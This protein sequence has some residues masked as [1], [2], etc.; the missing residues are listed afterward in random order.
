MVI[1]EELGFCFVRVPRTASTSIAEALLRLP[2]SKA[3]LAGQVA[4]HLQIPKKLKPWAVVREPYAR[5]LS[6]YWRRR[7]GTGD[8]L[9]SVVRGLSFK[10]YLRELP[11]HALAFDRAQSEW[12]PEEVEVLRYEELPN[13]LPDYVPELK[14]LNK[15]MATGDGYDGESAQIVYEMRRADFDV[16]GYDKDGWMGFNAEEYW[17]ERQRYADSSGNYKYT[18]EQRDEHREFKR[19]VLLG[20][21]NRHT[22]VETLA[23]FGA[24]DG[25]IT[26]DLLV[27]VDRLDISPEAVARMPSGRV[28]TAADLVPVDMIVAYDVLFHI[29]D[30]ERFAE[31]LVHIRKNCKLLLV[32]DGFYTTD[33]TMAR[34]CR[35][36]SMRE[37]GGFTEL[38]TWKLPNLPG[39]ATSRIKLLS[40][41]RHEV[42]RIEEVEEKEEVL[43]RNDDSTPFYDQF[44]GRGGWPYN[45]EKEHVALQP[46][47]RAAGWKKKFKILE[48]GCGMGTHAKILAFM[49]MDVWAVDVSEVAIEMAR[50]Q[51]GTSKNLHY[52][53]ADV[54]DVGKWRNDMEPFDGI[55]A[56]GMSYFHYELGGVNCKGIDV[57]HQTERM[58]SWLRDGGTFVLQI[59]TDLSGDR[60]DTVHSNT[61]RDYLDLFERFGRV[62]S[63]T[64]LEGNPVDE[65]TKGDPTRGPSKQGIILVVEKHGN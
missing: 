65:M 40:V 46:V 19:A 59:C 54:A 16:Y 24:G 53:A 18:Q 58:F 12:L 43:T 35:H 15:C 50:K 42:E 6:V 38:S 1:N 57:S 30:D 27:E 8:Y 23:D 33:K 17:L 55:Y 52:V 45:F 64:D 62:V 21:L 11:K 49:G 41:D 56:R 31:A 37:Y 7:A 22:W 26:R 2:G 61:Y 3:V 25:W 47:V 20:I 28:G 13:C 48:V 60:G 44:Y 39:L 9:G 5:E 51:H 29:V 34:H 63:F 14:H 10:E 4:H 36:R 32:L